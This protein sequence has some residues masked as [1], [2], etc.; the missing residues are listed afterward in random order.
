MEHFK[1]IMI[2][3]DYAT[4]LSSKCVLSQTYHQNTKHSK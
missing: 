1:S 2:S 3:N 4:R